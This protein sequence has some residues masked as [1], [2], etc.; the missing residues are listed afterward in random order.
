MALEYERL[1]I[2]TEGPVCRITLGDPDA[3][4]AL[5]D[6]MRQELLQAL[7]GAQAD[8]AVRV[9]LITGAGDSFCPGLPEGEVRA[10][11]EAGSGFER[12][13]PLLDEGRRLISLIDEFPKPVVAAINGPAHGEGAALALACDLRIADPEATL[14]LDFVRRAMAPAWGTSSTLA[15]LAGE[16]VALDLLWTGR[17]VGAEEALTLGLVERVSGSLPVAV[18]SVCSG[19]ASTEPE[20]L[21]LTRLA[22]QSSRACDL[23]QSLDLE[24]EIQHRSWSGSR[25]GGARG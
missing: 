1:T 20:L 9:V 14:S 24:T 11:R 13:R 21:H 8:D 3:G 18:E 4:N 25:Q 10:L 6:S 2:G 16:G 5:D 17:V 12:L 23:S 22:I 15:R 19:L 7:L